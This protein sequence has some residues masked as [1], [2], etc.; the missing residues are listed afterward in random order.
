MNPARAA[1]L[2][3]VA[4][5]VPALC[6]AQDL[7][8]RAYV[9]A[10]V[11][12]NAIILT[13][14]FSEGDILFLFDQT[15]PITDAMG[16]I[17]APVVGFYHALDFF[18]RS[19]N[20]SGGIPFATGD[21]EGKLTGQQQQLHRAGLADPVVRLS[22]NLRGGPA[23]RPAEFVKAGPRRS[24]LGA[25]V[26]VVV[27][28]GQY[29]HTRLI[30]I[31]TN[32]WA[33]KPELGYMHRVGR[34]I[35]DV[36]GGISGCTRPTTTTGRAT[37]TARAPSERRVRSAR[38]SHTSATTSHGSCGSPRTSTTGAADVPA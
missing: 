27:P 32:R 22:V 35:L 23:L 20:I 6:A 30:N 26:K 14:G 19:A 15:L 11:S 28:A 37:R 4:W 21:L 34:V 9:V 12:S 16:T 36:Y 2:V 31:G 38:S 7:T 8:P 10:P 33:F 1:I 29:D 24:V 5:L 25:S 18:G 13:H 17:H 3:A